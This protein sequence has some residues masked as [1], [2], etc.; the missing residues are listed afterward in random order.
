MNEKL[1]A[2]DIALTFDDVLVVPGWSEVLPSGVDLRARLARGIGLGIPLVS[3]AMDTVTGSS[4]AIALARMG[5]IGII[6]RNLSPE[7][8]AR[9]VDR[10]KRSESGMILDPVCLHESATLGEAKRIMGSCRISGIPVVEASTR[11]HEGLITVKD[12]QKKADYPHAALDASGRLLV[13]AAVG[14]GQDLETRIALLVSKG[15][16]IVAVDTAHGHSQGVIRAIRRIKAMAPDLAVIAGNV[17]TAEGTAAL[18]DAGADAIKVGVGAGSICTTRIVSGCGM[19]QLSAIRACADEAKKRGV[20]VIADGGVKYSGDIV[21]AIAAGAETVMLGSLLAGLEE[22]P[23]ELILYNGRQYKSYR[24]MGSMG[25]LQGYG[26]DRYGTG[27]SGP[28]KLV[29]EGV[30]GM[31]PYK[32]RLEDFVYQLLGGL[33]SGMGYAGAGCLDDLRTK[34]SLVRITNAGLAES[35]PHGITITREA[36]NYNRGD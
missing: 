13:G 34:T 1:F 9:E 11:K 8:Q 32:G 20:P 6:H 3:A 5:G 2:G 18:A 26:R 17:V 24:G 33:R 36:P 23:G 16:N 35:H 12:I 21:K 29:P 10:V 19:P 27:Q 28:D 14:V 31:V 4:L 22:S 25:A 15:V 7:E 30:E